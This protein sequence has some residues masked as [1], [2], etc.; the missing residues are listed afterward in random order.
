MP[1]TKKPPKPATA[2]APA[3]NAAAAPGEVLTLAE[4]AAYLRLSEADVLRGV[5]AQGLPARQLGAEWR[6]SRSA[7]QDWLRTGPPPGPSKEAQLATIG[8]WKDDPYLK[9]MLEEI[10]RKRGRPMT[11]EA[12]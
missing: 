8:S 4:A 3:G 7:I 12:E 6:F 5:H 9:E 2:P 10:Y 11:E 1:R